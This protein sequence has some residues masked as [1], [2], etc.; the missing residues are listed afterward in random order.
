[1]VPRNSSVFALL[2]SAATLSGCAA[3]GPF[4]SLAARP[5]EGLISVAEPVRPPVSVAPNAALRAQVAALRERGRS[6]A[7]AFDAA[8][9]AAERAT[10]SVGASGSDSWIAAQQAVS[11]LEAARGGATAALADLDRLS[12]DRADTPTNAEDYALIG[13]AMA[14]IERETAERQT[15]LDALRSRL[16]R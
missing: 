15:R 7:R 2:A 14:E 11:R 1:M 9:P 3:A 16:N 10:R 5:E 13:A 8:Y 4:P 6:G 12:M